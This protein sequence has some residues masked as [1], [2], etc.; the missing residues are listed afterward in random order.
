MAVSGHTVLV[1]AFHDDDLGTNSGSA[2]FFGD[3]TPANGPP[4]ITQLTIP[5]APVPVNTPVAVSG[6]FT[7][8]GT[9]SGSHAYTEPGVYIVGLTVTDAAGAEAHLLRCRTSS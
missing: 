9:V 3:L 4:V 7:D 2:Y 6:S 5:L 1:G 8:A